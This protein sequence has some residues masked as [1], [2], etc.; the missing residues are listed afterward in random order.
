MTVVWTQIANLLVRKT[1]VASIFNFKRLF[2]NTVMIYSLIFE[3]VLITLLVYVPGLNNFF[4][5]DDITSKQASVGLWM[6]PVIFIFDE[7]RKY[8]IR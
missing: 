3:T 6:L 5:L 1:Q 2:G 8:K 4:T 7:V